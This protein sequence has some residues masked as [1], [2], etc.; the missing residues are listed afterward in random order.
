MRA[1]LCDSAAT[2]IRTIL[3]LL[4]LATGSCAGPD[5]R[6]TTA[7]APAAEAAFRKVSSELYQAYFDHI[8]TSFGGNL[9]V[10]LGMHQY[11]GRLPDNSAAALQ[12]ARRS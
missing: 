10:S 1:I 6:S 5:H 2:R 7:P 3:L 12:G 4:L 11:D 9:G 8:P